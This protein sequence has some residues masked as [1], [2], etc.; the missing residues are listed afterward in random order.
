M[1][2]PLGTL[3]SHQL[4]RATTSEPTS[5]L[6]TQFNYW[7]SITLSL[8]TIIG[9]VVLAM[10]E[11]LLGMLLVWVVV[12]LLRP[13]WPMLAVLSVGFTLGALV[14]NREIAWCWPLGLVIPG[15]LWGVLP[16]TSALPFGQAVWRST[17]VELEAGPLLFLA[18]QGFLAVRE[19]TLPS[20]IAHQVEERRAAG[21]RANNQLRRGTGNYPSVVSPPNA[22]LL[23]D[24]DHPSGGI[25]LGALRDN[26][27]KAFDLTFDEL[28]LH[29]FLPG[30]SGSGKTTTLERLADGALG[31]GAGLVII[32]CKGGGLGASARKLADAY[33]LPF[34]VVDP[35]DPDT[36]GYNPCDGSPSD[37]A[38]K[39]IGSFTFGEAGEIYKQVG[40]NVVPLLVKGLRSARLSVSLAH[41]AEYASPNGLRLLAHKVEDEDLGDQL[42]A[43]L[44]DNDTA[45][46]SG[47]I[48]LQH[49]FGA[50]LQGSFGPLFKQKD[51]LDWDSAF[52]QPMVVYI[53]LS[54]TAASEDVDL[55]GRV[56]IQD[57]KQ[58]CSRRLRQSAK[59]EELVPV[60]CA[61]DEFAALNEARQIIDLLLQARQAAM[62]LLLSTQFVPQDPDL[63]KAVLQAG[64]LVVHR[65]EAQDAQDLAAQFGTRPSWK[66]TH[67]IDWET[68]T[69][70]KG[71][72]RDVEEYVIHPNTLRRLPVGTAAIRSVQTDRHALVEVLRT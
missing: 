45:G 14:L 27:R 53:C 49:R 64:L 33:N 69:T 43:F 26:R 30:A 41:L 7:T 24:P 61:I 28:A 29:T 42:T 8:G 1:A 51:E 47:V 52:A 25:R 56:L 46:K 5:Q 3:G 12:R 59:G 35:D 20:G 4:H 67:Q 21:P 38:N 66:V 10:P 50:I 34:C 57:L 62:P 15:R 13:P 6:G 48:S 68:G 36:T 55:M 60:L 72:I 58:A 19:H 32:D 16:P 37:V 39:L 18:W 40:M 22:S 11:V 23:Q 65:L 71:S 54:A 2:G 44:D 70:A 31:L 17:L 9:I 63:K